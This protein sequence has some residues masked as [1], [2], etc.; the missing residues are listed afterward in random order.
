MEN[1][2]EICECAFGESVAAIQN[3]AKLLQ[4]SREEAYSF[5]V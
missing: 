4:T 3:A 5:V 1:V 2:E